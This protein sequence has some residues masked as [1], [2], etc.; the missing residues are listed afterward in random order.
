M[1]DAAAKSKPITKRWWFPTAV[2]VLVLLALVGAE[3][4]GLLGGGQD[5]ICAARDF[6]VEMAGETP[7][8][9]P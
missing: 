8:A 6:F 9:C 1:P 3:E 4:L 7:D 2:V 5:A